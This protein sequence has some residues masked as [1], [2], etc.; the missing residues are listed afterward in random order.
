MPLAAGLHMWCGIKTAERRRVRR[1]GGSD[2]DTIG[3]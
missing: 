3:Q 1:P 2:Y